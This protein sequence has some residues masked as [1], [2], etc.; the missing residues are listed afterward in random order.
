MRG[1]SR[2]PSALPVTLIRMVICADCKHCMTAPTSTAAVI[3]SWPRCA[4]SRG[5]FVFKGALGF[6]LCNE[7]NLYGKCTLFEAKEPVISKI[8]LWRR[9][10]DFWFF[11]P[12][13]AKEP[14]VCNRCG[15]P[16]RRGHDERGLPG[17]MMPHPP[18]CREQMKAAGI[19]IPPSPTVWYA[20]AQCT[21]SYQ[22]IDITRN[23]QP[24]MPVIVNREATPPVGDS[25]L[26]AARNNSGGPVQPPAKLPSVTTREIKQ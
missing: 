17:W 25:G 7:V 10:V 19:E 11:R 9:F 16:F 5:N 2:K 15:Q 12:I 26:P 14:K 3:D 6:K 24:V 20:R 23:Y 4:A 18:D 8:S 22:P 13:R 1:R 21:D